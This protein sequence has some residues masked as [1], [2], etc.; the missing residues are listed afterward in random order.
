MS[1][2]FDTMAFCIILP[3]AFLG[4]ILFGIVLIIAISFS[5]AFVEAA[6]G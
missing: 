2:L 1:E 6:K 5:I 3:I 4:L